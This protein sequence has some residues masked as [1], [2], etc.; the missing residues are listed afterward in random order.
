MSK[1]NKIDVP[2]FKKASLANSKKYLGLSVFIDDEFFKE[3]LAQHIIEKA[4]KAAE[5]I[6]NMPRKQ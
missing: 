1:E 2:V 6:S 3:T 5:N 4:Q